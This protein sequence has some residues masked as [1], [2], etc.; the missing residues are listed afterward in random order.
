MLNK[1]HLEDLFAGVED[2]HISKGSEIAF[3]KQLKKKG[4]FIWDQFKIL[5]KNH[6]G[7]NKLGDLDG[8]HI[9]K[10]IMKSEQIIIPSFS[11]K[12]IDPLKKTLTS[13]FNHFKII[14]WIAKQPKKVHEYKGILLLL[15]LECFLL[16]EDTLLLPKELH[17]IN[18][19][20]YTMIKEYPIFMFDKGCLELYSCQVLE[21]ILSKIKI[22]HR[23]TC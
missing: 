8:A 22:H 5:L 7:R 11:K 15:S 19:Y 1:H 16:G 9:T 20:L 23:S 4:Y 18:L 14:S 10:L 17:V 13:I 6:L 12:V 2:L 21:G 3:I